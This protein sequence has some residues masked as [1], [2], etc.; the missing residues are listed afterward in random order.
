MHKIFD[1]VDWLCKHDDADTT[2][3]SFLSGWFVG[4]KV[5][6]LRRGNVIEFLAWA[7]Y[8][9]KWS[10]TEPR[11]RVDIMVTVEVVEGRLGPGFK[12]GPGFNPQVAGIRHTLDPVVPFSHRPLA[13]YVFLAFG[14]AVVRAGLNL[15]GFRRSLSPCGTF[16]YWFREA[17]SPSSGAAKGVAAA[18]QDGKKG[19]P[20]LGPMVLFHGV[21]TGLPFY[22]LALW[23]MCRRRVS[24]W[25][26]LGSALLPKMMKRSLL[27]GKGI[28]D[29]KSGGGG[30]RGAP[31]RMTQQCACTCF[32][33]RT[34]GVFVDSPWLE[35]TS[36]TDRL[37]VANSHTVHAPRFL[38]GSYHITRL[39]VPPGLFVLGRSLSHLLVADLGHSRV[40]FHRDE[41]G[42]PARA[43]APLGEPAGG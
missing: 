43:Q 31:R 3:E 36:Q 16:F 13:L 38:F 21:G 32:S 2:F 30:G 1:T 10:A 35:E 22:V 39:F 7:M 27:R 5:S 23:K 18:A 40:S 19:G 20:E 33:A 37:Q 25:Y 9:K 26:S 8:A 6:E 4:A 12:F 42:A 28:H 14:R 29:G 11:E 41:P 34:S 15:W 24:R 17:S